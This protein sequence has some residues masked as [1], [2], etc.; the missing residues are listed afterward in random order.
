MKVAT[1]KW[2]HIGDEVTWHSPPLFTTRF[3]RA[4]LV[5]RYGPPQL[6]AVE[7]DGSV[8]FDAWLVRF[9][10]GL[11]VAIWSFD[12]SWCG[13]HPHHDR[14][15]VE[16]HAN[17]RDRDHLLF[18]L[19]LSSDAIDE[20]QPT[21]LITEPLVHQILRLDDNGNEFEVTRVSSACQAIAI[22]QTYEAR[23]HK[24]TYW[25]RKVG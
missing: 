4:K 13:P 16:V 23:G 5:A 3:P 10:C 18:H 2:Q 19:G 22:A 14:D 8:P 7:T 9:G 1:E 24:Q 17:R 21:R 15:T 12:N 11:E 6:V 20:R 25:A